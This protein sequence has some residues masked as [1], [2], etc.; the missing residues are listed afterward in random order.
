MRKTIMIISLLGLVGCAAPQYQ[1]AGANGFH[2]L[3]YNEIKLTDT[4]IRVTY[5]GSS[6][7]NAYMGFMRRA[8]ELTKAAGK[9]YFTVTNARSSRDGISNSNGLYDLTVPKYSG[10]INMH[11]KRSPS[12]IKASDILKGVGK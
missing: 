3:G 5:L 2:R 4:M 7:D 10:T 11:V 12:S 8:A 1:K 6:D 9:E